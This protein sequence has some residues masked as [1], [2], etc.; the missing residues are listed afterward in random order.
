MSL[1]QR[2]SS[3]TEE[4][5]KRIIREDDDHCLRRAPA[6]LPSASSAARRRLLPPTIGSWSRA[7]D[8]DKA[9][10][11][12]QRL[13]ERL[14]APTVLFIGLVRRSWPW[15]V[16]HIPRNLESGDVSITDSPSGRLGFKIG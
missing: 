5:V 9:G 11:G 6:R 8:G 3:G 14:G 16:V 10:L 7:G 1:K 15:I 13:D 12:W 4:N 2:G